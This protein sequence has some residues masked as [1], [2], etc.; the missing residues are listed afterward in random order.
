MKELETRG[1]GRR[2]EDRSAIQSRIEQAFSDLGITL[3]PESRQQ[4][5]AEVMNELFG[6]GPIQHLLDDPSV[7]EI[8][9]NRADRVYAERGGKPVRTEAVFDDEAHLIRHI[10]RIVQSIGRKIDAR[11]PM[12]DARLADG[13]RVNAV[14]APATID[15]ACLTIRKFGKKI[16]SV[17][18]LIKFGTLTPELVQFL[19]ACV[20]AHLNI[21]VAGSTGSGKTTLLNVLSSLVPDNERIITIEDAA[22]LQ[23]GQDHV[24]R[25]E[26]KKADS[27]GSGELTIRELLRNALRMRPERI[28]VGECRGGEALDMLQALNTGHGGS[29]TTLHANTPRDVISRIETM[30]LMGGIDFP[31]KAIRTQIAS[32]INLVVQTA[33]IKD[34]SRRITHVTEVAGMEG[35]TVVLQDI[36]KLVDAPDRSGA[37]IVRGTGSRPLFEPK[38]VAAGFQLPPAIYNGNGMPKARAA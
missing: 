6:L 7:S 27:D 17:D 15:G 30:A 14:I 18:D 16:T 8:M 5:L 20:Q 31:L 35:E 12:V 21:V 19:T 1:P 38:L 9:V 4:L 24:V 26:S 34:G 2:A 10:E 36:F 28:I 22:E 11:N 37:K 13:S 33:R 23:L 32:A 3:S 25:L 29:M